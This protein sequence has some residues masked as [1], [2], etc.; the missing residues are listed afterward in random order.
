MTVTPSDASP[1]EMIPGDIT[2]AK[3]FG[4]RAAEAVAKFVK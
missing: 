2:T 3:A 4:Q 1:D